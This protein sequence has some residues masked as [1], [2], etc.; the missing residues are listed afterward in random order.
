MSTSAHIYYI[1]PQGIHRMPCSSMITALWALQGRSQQ[2]F[3]LKGQTV[4]IS[5][6]SGH[7]QSLSHLLKF[8]IAK[9]K[10]DMAVFQKKLYLQT[11]KFEFHIIF[12]CH[13]TLLFTFFRHLK[14]KN[15][16]QL[17]AC[18]KTGNRPQFAKLC[19]RAWVLNIKIFHLYFH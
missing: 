19:C 8:L 1:Q 2:S 16:S 10:L 9:Q 12:M 3:P 6:F 7:M 18:T 11:L 13:K 5:G 4:N 15:H 14:N 17:V